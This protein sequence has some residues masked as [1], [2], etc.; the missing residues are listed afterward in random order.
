LRDYFSRQ[1][2]VWFAPQADE[3]FIDGFSW[4]QALLAVALTDYRPREF[5]TCAPM[6]LTLPPHGMEVFAR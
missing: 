4:Q 3:I 5:P 6:L 2:L 1:M